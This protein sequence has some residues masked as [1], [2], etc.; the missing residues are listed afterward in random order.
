M[1]QFNNSLRQINILMIVFVLFNFFIIKVFATDSINDQM[2][3]KALNKSISDFFPNRG[4]ME[5]ILEADVPYVIKL[6]ASGMEIS[7]ISGLE[8]FV[9][10]QST[11]DLS[12]NNINN[13]APLI[14]WVRNKNNKN[15]RANIF[16]G[17]NPILSSENSKQIYILSELGENIRI[18]D[19]QR[20]GDSVVELV[21][22]IN[23]RPVEEIKFDNSLSSL[24]L[25]SESK[26]VI[27][28]TESAG[29]SGKTTNQNDDIV[30]TGVATVFVY[31]ISCFIILVVLW[32]CI[33][34]KV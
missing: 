6:D 10:I 16:L 4:S 8:Q 20:E 22:F 18:Y 15:L 30:D 25:E 29:E 3:L 32:R 1:K 5:E 17:E 31:I 33:Y 9:Y 21:G 23:G 28:K 13:I 34:K 24:S 14:N 27:N 11:I 26:E 12:N 19:S 7:D 2:L